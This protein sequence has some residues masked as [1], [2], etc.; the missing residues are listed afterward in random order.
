MLRSALIFSLACLLAAALCT[1]AFGYVLPAPFVASQMQKHLNLPDQMEITQQ[2]HVYP[3]EA[4]GKSQGADSVGQNS[5][6]AEKDSDP[7]ASGPAGFF[8]TVRYRRP[9]AYRSDIKTPDFSQIYI[10]SSGSQLF[11]LDGEIIDDSRQW[12]ACYK[13][14]FMFLS[15]PPLVRHLEQLGVDMNISS[16]GRLNKK[17]VYVAGAR[18]PDLSSAQVWFDKNTFLPVRWIVAPAK[19]TGQPPAFEIRYLDWQPFDGIRYPGKIEF[20]E[21]GRLARAVTVEKLDRISGVPASDFDI[22]AVR[23]KYAPASGAPQEQGG[24]AEEVRRQIEEF[25]KIY[26]TPTQ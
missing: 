19:Q 25:K 23:K 10:E 13:D 22:S 4:D 20:Y 11:V 1:G 12:Y 15:R 18:Y 24:A 9:G 3:A 14:L 26:E 7:E 2:L 5:A 16:L 6:D 21:N 17:T 8:Q